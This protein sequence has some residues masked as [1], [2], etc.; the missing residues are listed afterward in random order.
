MAIYYPEMY[1]GIGSTLKVKKTF[2]IEFDD[3][4]IQDFSLD[5]LCIV[6]D[7]VGYGFNIKAMNDSKIFR[8][9]NG[10]MID[11][12]KLIELIPYTE[13][14]PPNNFDSFPLVTFK[15]KFKIDD[16]VRISVNDV[17]RHEIS[18]TDKIFHN[19]YDMYSRRLVLR[20]NDDEFEEYLK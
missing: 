18:K 19:L 4:T 10:Q 5:D 2:E 6:E 16:V 13:K 9:K 20:L 15:K 7:I 17:F 8:I 3:G 1:C 14:I 12:F 11:Y